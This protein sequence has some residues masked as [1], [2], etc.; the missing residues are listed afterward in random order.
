MLRS[1]WGILMP[2]ASIGILILCLTVPAMAQ[3]QQPK[4][5]FLCEPKFKVEPTFTWE[6]WAKAPRIAETD[7]Q[8]NTTIRKTESEYLFETVFAVDIPTTVPHVSF[9]FETILKPFEKGSS[10]ELETELNLHWLRSERTGGWVGSHFDIVD[11]YSRGNL[12][13]NLDRYTHKLDFELDT[14]VAFLKWAK[15]PWLSDIE[16]EASLDYLASGLVR[17]GDTFGNVTYLD[18]ASRWGFSLVFVIPLAPL[19]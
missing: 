16:I 5:F 11:K 7:S 14:A 13:H 6:N 15:K 9:T 1:T 8:G 10:P 3:D 12:P 18:N 19:R 2:F 4:C 17:A